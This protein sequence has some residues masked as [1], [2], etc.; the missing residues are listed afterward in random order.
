MT[1]IRSIPDALRCRRLM[2]G[3]SYKELCS[4]TGLTTATINNVETGRHAVRASTAALL[5]EALGAEFEELFCLE[6]E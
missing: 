5:C 1:I 2:A 3:I 6:D 4:R